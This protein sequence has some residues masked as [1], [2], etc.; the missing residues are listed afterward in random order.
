[1]FITYLL[2]KLLQLG[3]S[4]LFLAGFYVLL[5]RHPSFLSVPSSSFFPSLLP[6]PFLSLPPSSL[7]SIFPSFLPLFPSL[8]FYLFFA[9]LNSSRLIL[10]FPYSSQTTP[11]TSPKNLSNFKWRMLLTKNSYCCFCHCL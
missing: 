10:H 1:M 7:S 6:L 11:I 4:E 5:T 9:F 3:Q 8:S 2:L